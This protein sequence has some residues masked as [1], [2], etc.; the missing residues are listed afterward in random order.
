MEKGFA[1]VP[2]NDLVSIVVSAFRA[3][4]SHALALTARAVPSLEEDNR[5]LPMLTNISKQYLGE[6]YSNK[7]SKTGSI[8]LEDI[9]SLA[10]TAYPLCMRQL[11]SA[12][13]EDHHLKHGGRQQY[14]LFLKGIGLTMEQALKFWRTEFS[15]KMDADKF[16]KQYAYNI[17]HSFGKEGKRVNYTPYSCMKIIMGTQ[18]GPGDYHGCP[19][20]HTDVKLLKQRLASYKIPTQGIEQIADLVKGYHYQLACTKYFELTHNI[21]KDEVSGLSLQHPNQYFDASMDIQSGKLKE[22]KGGRFSQGNNASG[23]YNSQRSSGTQS[24]SKSQMSNTQQSANTSTATIVDE[25]GWDNFTG[26]DMEKLDS[27]VAMDTS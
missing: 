5:L 10:K 8:A 27:S 13:R 3:H 24:S 11:H 12:L 22:S 14:G 19:F 2:H 4:L 7:N 26:E 16:E 25:E 9:D 17:R 18:P 23:T 6:D 15:K 1:Y 21:D 20:R